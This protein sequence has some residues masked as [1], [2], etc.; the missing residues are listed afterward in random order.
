M[1]SPD[2]APALMFPPLPR[3]DHLLSR[4][5]SSPNQSLDLS[6]EEIDRILSRYNLT[7][8]RSPIDV[9][10][11]GRSCRI[12]LHTEQGKAI[13]KRY[14][15]TLI[16][17]AVRHSHSILL[18]LSERHF[19]A[20]RL[21]PT[22]TGDTILVQEDGYYALFEYLEGYFQYHHY[23]LFPGQAQRFIHLA[24]ESLAALH[25]TLADFKPEGYNP[26]GFQ[27]RTGKRWRELSWYLNRLR[28]CRNAL[29]ALKA[30]TQ[31]NI[32]RVIDQNA[33]W[34]EDKLYALDE[35]LRDANLPRYLIHGDYGPYNLFFKPKAPVVILDFELA[36]LDWRLMD[37]AKA[38]QH[39][40]RSRLGFS[41][42]K[43]KAFFEGYRRLSNLPEA[44]FSYLPEAWLFL[45][46]RRLVVCWERYCRQAHEPYIQ[47]STEILALA[48]WIE[49]HQQ[50]LRDLIKSR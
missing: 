24:G 20:P 9:Q 44:E 28:E 49:E 29:P 26:D 40:T 30:S 2:L 10:G 47:E 27:S 35:T 25:E 16:L 48:T 15:H 12:I 19:P 50:L 36:S 21:I 39:F 3:P 32:S 5:L 31:K 14:K 4:W 1:R 13:L 18:H 23:L 41:W 7:T 42:W 45:I 38:L 37:F 17:P 34:L 43:M 33:T 46:L 11:G 8:P 22:I 6:Q